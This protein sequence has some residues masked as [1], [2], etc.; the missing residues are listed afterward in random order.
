M[1]MTVPAVDTIQHAQI[2]GLT[3]IWHQR[4]QFL[5]S[6]SMLSIKHLCFSSLFCI[7]TAENYFTG[8]AVSSSQNKLVNKPKLPSSYYIKCSL[9]FGV[10]TLFPTCPSFMN[11]ADHLQYFVQNYRYFNLT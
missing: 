3:H 1:G 7:I 5:Y 11:S 10:T 8:S 6:F 9:C 2:Q 4:L